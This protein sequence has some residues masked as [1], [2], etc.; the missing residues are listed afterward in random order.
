VLSRKFKGKFLFHLKQ[1]WKNGEI[2][3]YNST[4]YLGQEINFLN[5]LSYLYQKD[6]VV[7]CKKP[8]KSPWHVISYLG[9]YTHRVAI[10]NSR[11]INFDRDTVQFKWKD[12]KEQNRVKLM[13]LE[14]AEFV[15]RFLLHVLPSGFTR[16][17][18]YGLLA[19]RNVGTKLAHCI[20]LAEVMVVAP[21]L[22]RHVATCPLCGG[23]MAFSGCVNRSGAVP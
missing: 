15:R 19:S 14:V 3:F 18:H 17:R 22:V 16:I 11:I 7:Y 5:L 9:R 2:K 20:K 1:A 23:V 13:T 4:E 10:A 8:F 6:W 21:S 12:Y